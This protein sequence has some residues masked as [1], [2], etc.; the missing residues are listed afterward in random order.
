MMQSQRLLIGMS[1]SVAFLHIRCFIGR[2]DLQLDNLSD[3]RKLFEKVI[4]KPAVILDGTYTVCITGGC[5]VQ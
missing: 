5:L 1:A 2:Q 4:Y 3:G